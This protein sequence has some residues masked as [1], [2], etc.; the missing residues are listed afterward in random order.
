VHPS[1]GILQNVK[2]VADFA[3]IVYLPVMRGQQIGPSQIEV[4]RRR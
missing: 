4:T 3:E 2:Q 1:E